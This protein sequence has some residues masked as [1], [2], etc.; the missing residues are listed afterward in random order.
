MLQLTFTSQAALQNASFKLKKLVIPFA[1]GP[2][3]I[4]IGEEL[5]P[6]VLEVMGG[7]P[8]PACSSGTDSTQVDEYAGSNPIL[9]GLT[10]QKRLLVHLP[11]EQKLQGLAELLEESKGAQIRIIVAN[12]NQSKDLKHQLADKGVNSSYAIDH[13]SIA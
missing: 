1:Q 11:R 4:H 10:R 3:C 9:V 7:S 5:A 8:L 12:D 13:D 2:D 6:L